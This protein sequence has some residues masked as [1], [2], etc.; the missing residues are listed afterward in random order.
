MRGA[1]LIN[2][3]ILVSIWLLGLATALPNFYIYNLC[4]LPK[5]QRFKCEKMAPDY[6]DDRFYMI[7]L[8]GKKT[9]ERVQ[10]E[11]RLSSFLLLH[12]HRGDDRPLHVDH[13]GNVSKK[14]GAENA[15]DPR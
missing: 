10:P 8:D 2:I 13:F 7:A 6:F 11:V 12:S 3:L 14:Y 15:I 4:F 1:S 5:M 9:S